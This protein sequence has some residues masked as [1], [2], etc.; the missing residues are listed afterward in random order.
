MLALDLET[1]GLDKEN[2][3][4]T[5]LG[6]VL[7]DENN[8][9]SLH[10]R[11][12]KIK[13]DI[14]AEAASVT[15]LSKEFLQKSGEPIESVLFSFLQDVYFTHNLKPDFIVA[16]N[17][18]LFDEPIFRRV[19][20][21]C[22]KDSTEPEVSLTLNTPWIDTSIDVPYPKH[23]TTRKLTYLSLEHGYVNAKAHRAVFDCLSCVH[24]MQHYG[25]EAV[26]KYKNTKKFKVTAK[27]VE[28]WKDGS[29]S[30]D[31]AKENGFRYNPDA[32]LWTKI[33]R[34]DE[35]DSLKALPI[36]FT[37]ESL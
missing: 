21:S 1:T 23:I 27:T 25:F 31:T 4:I 7:F 28:P 16:H 33:M 30:K 32:K 12:V 22:F 17:G 37:M 3:E 34:E 29:K 36:E 8:I 10:N 26:L 20:S 11:L 18:T 9:I 5:E 13:G 35:L 14:S 19:F 15:G 24:I 6:Y 2:C